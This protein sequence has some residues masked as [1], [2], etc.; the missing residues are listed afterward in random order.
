MFISKNKIIQLTVVFVNMFIVAINM[1]NAYFIQNFS[2]GKILGYAL[3]PPLLVFLLLR[4]IQEKKSR[5]RLLYFALVFA[6]VYIIYRQM[7]GINF[8]NVAGDVQRIN[9]DINYGRNIDFER[10]INILRIVM[11]FGSAILSFSFYI[12]PYNIIIL[13][14]GLMF[15]LWIIDYEKNTYNYVRY[16]LPVWAFSILSYRSSL[17]DSE[18]KNFKVNRS[19]RLFQVVIISL[20]ITITSLFIN[21]DPKGVYSNRLWNYFN[22]Q[23]IPTD[24]IFGTNILN[25]F[26][27]TTSGYNDSDKQLGGNISI[28]NDE[29]LR[30]TADEPLYLRGSVRSVYTGNR[31]EK[32][33]VAYYSADHIEDLRLETLNR[34]I[35]NSDELIK[36]AVIEPTK[37]NTATIFSG[38]YTRD[39]SFIDSDAEIYYDKINDA[40][41]SDTTVK[42]SYYIN[43]FNEGS[44]R[45][46]IVQNPTESDQVDSKY[47]DTSFRVTNRTR[48]L[49]SSIVDNS[50]TDYEKASIL[51]EYLK[52]HYTYSI[53]PGNLPSGRDFVDYFLFEVTEGYCVHFATALTIMLRI[54]GVPTRY[55]EGYKMGS[56]MV[57]GKFVVRNSDAHAWTEVLIDKENDIWMNF[58]ATGT[59]RELI[60]GEEPVDNNDV[61]VQTP[62]ENPSTTT[63]ETNTNQPGFNGENPEEVV[64]TDNNN[65]FGRFV[66]I[67]LGVAALFSIL[68]MLYK[69]WKLKRAIE[70][71]S[72][73]PYFKEVTKLLGYIR[74]EREKGETYLELSKRI[75]DEELRD[76]FRFLVNEIYKEEYSDELGIYEKR[77]ELLDMLFLK[78][79][80]HRG[81]GFYYLRRFLL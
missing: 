48:Q 78:V 61:E 27:L 45:R 22:S 18:T 62:S 6:C 12:F 55:V 51:T 44:I 32:D 56:E 24:Q 5:L 59:P 11:L 69:E 57:E 52:E 9:T 79:R 58:D 63:N 14:M 47:L 8:G 72:L 43:Y 10:F 29:A 1:E 46:T 64:T 49:V 23:V 50:M 4:F 25:P 13:D 81:K 40:F 26:N 16:F 53:K 35:G 70:D 68:R 30:V 28:N 34:M 15:F 3:T 71:S 65:L 20:I 17:F 31:W 76:E 41:T 38:I 74:Y 67:L 60:F 21:I 36:T 2:Y 66:L 37:E 80:I 54:A 7:L 73:K 75:K 77:R 33:S 39:V 19:A 42:D